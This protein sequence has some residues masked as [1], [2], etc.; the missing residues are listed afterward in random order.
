MRLITRN[1]DNSGSRIESTTQGGVSAQII[2]LRRLGAKVHP[3]LRRLLEAYVLFP[4]FAAMLLVLA[5]TAV[6]HLVTVEHAVA[7]D[8]AAELSR[9]LADTY[10]AQM[11]RNLVAIDQALKTVKYVY[12]RRGGAGCGCQNCRTRACCLSRSCSR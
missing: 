12:E 9:E 3:A 6:I 8:A 2:R 10:E 1:L 7:R 4:L 11:V 5:W